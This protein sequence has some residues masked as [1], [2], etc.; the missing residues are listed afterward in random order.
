MIV[1]RV[2][3]EEGKE[4]GFEVGKSSTGGQVGRV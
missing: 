3:N 1:E 2:G 4:V